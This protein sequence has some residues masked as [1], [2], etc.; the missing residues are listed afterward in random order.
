MPRS[1]ASNL[2][3]VRREMEAREGG[4]GEAVAGMVIK[5]ANR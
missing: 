1:R 4:F 2:G 5:L 3:Q